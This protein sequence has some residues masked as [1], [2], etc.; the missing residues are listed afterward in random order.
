M[1]ATNN[2][3][4]EAFKTGT[5]AYTRDGRKAT[6]VGICERCEI[7]SKLLAYIEGSPQVA[8]L[9]L[10]GRFDEYMDEPEDLVRMP[11]PYDHLKPGDLVMVWWNT[12]D[13]STANVR[14]FHSVDETGRPQFIS[15]Q[16]RV[17]VADNIMPID[18][19]AK[20]YL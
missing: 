11:T 17:Q 2:F 5:P 7:N 15:I 4:L 10:D 9:F 12:E 6:F 14:K 20:E 1:E 19:Y 13:P 8:Q 3:D 18:E 16:G